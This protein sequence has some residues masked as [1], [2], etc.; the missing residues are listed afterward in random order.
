MPL[1]ASEAFE[2]FTTELA[3]DVI[4]LLVFVVLHPSVE[5]RHHRFNFVFG[6]V[7][8]VSAVEVALLA[9]VVLRLIDLVA[10]HFF[11]GCKSLAAVVVSALDFQLLAVVLIRH[12]DG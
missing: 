1:P 2:V 3:D 8:P 6:E 4:W 7:V 9:V 11:L 5:P 10:S 12:D